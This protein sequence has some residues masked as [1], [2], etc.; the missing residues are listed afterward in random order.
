M[1]LFASLFTIALIGLGGCSNTGSFQ[2]APSAAVVPGQPAVS[3]VTASDVRDEKPNRVATIR[4]GY[5]NP[6]QVLDLARPVGDGV[7]G[8][9]TAAL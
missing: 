3:A 5:G 8:V 6:V 7:T 9:V 1:R 4:G 2:Y